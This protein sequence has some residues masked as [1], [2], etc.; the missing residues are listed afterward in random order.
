M[1]SLEIDV[2]LYDHFT[3]DKVVKAIPWEKK[4][5]F[6]QMILQQPDIKI[7]KK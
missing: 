6:Q 5:C 3:F 2:H 4:V 1:E 7:E